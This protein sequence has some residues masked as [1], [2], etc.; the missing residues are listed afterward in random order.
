MNLKVPIEPHHLKGLY[1]AAIENNGLLAQ[2]P[3]FQMLP[4]QFHTITQDNIIEILQDP[5][6]NWDFSLFLLH[7]FH[8]NAETMTYPG[9]REILSTLSRLCKVLTDTKDAQTI[10]QSLIAEDILDS[11]SYTILLQKIRSN[12]S[13]LSQRIRQLD[14]DIDDA[15]HNENYLV[16]TVY[17]TLLK[18]SRLLYDLYDNSMTLLLP[19]DKTE[20]E[21]LKD[22]DPPFRI[23]IAEKRY[24][25]LQICAPRQGIVDFFPLVILKPFSLPLL[26]AEHPLPIAL[27]G[28]HFKASALHDGRLMS[29]LELWWHDIITHKA[30]LS[31]N[32]CFSTLTEFLQRQ[33][34]QRHTH[35]H[36]HW[37][38]KAQTPRWQNSFAAHLA[39][40]FQ[41]QA[42]GD[43]VNF[44]QVASSISDVSAIVLFMCLHEC[45]ALLTSNM[46]QRFFSAPLY[47]LL[48][49][50]NLFLDTFAKEKAIDWTCFFIENNNYSDWNADSLS[51]Y[52][53]LPL[54]GQ[55]PIHLFLALLWIHFSVTSFAHGN[56]DFTSE[57]HIK[58]F[59][60]HITPL[61]ALRAKLFKLAQMGNSDAI[62]EINRCPQV[63]DLKVPAQ[64][65]DLHRL[66]NPLQ[67]RDLSA[68]TTVMKSCAP[69]AAS[70]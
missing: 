9:G 69:Q 54:N 27:S 53:Q 25:A 62:V 70:A 19:S 66:F 38:Q 68:P 2:H 24:D 14:F 21:N 36:S 29:G 11:H 48:H 40:L 44:Q 6:L 3:I 49:F 64:Y 31:Y 57:Q 20:R 45:N 4:H 17:E 63:T 47:S 5:Y 50:T 18:A 1:Q 35:P 10:A 23:V 15:I 28:T 60:S 8:D 61:I 22:T 67:L 51:G 13:E 16:N 33:T 41:A 37:L 65:R 52:E 12:E 43:T 42:I 59:C 55:S 7:S 56:N 30:I 32:I 39:T 26:I 58:D 46:P 34:C